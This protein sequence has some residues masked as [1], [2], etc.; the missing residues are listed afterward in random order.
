M[1]KRALRDGRGRP[2]PPLTLRCLLRE[3]DA[4]DALVAVEHVVVVGPW[5]DRGLS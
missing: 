2:E 1:I 4:S 3:Q 5:S